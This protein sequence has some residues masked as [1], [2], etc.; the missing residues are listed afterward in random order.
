MATYQ[1]TVGNDFLTGTDVNDTFYGGQGDDFL[2]GKG[3]DDT[4]VLRGS[5]GWDDFDGGNGIDTISVQEVQG[6]WNFIAIQVAFLTS[7]EKIQN[8]SSTTAHIYAR[9]SL[10]LSN[11]EL[12]NIS[13]IRGQATGDYITGNSIANSIFGNDGAD[14]LKGLGGNDKLDGGTGNDTIAGGVGDDALYGGAG[15]DRFY[16][17]T[18]DAG[19]DTIH[20]FQDGI[21][22][23]QLKSGTAYTFGT[24]TATGYAT[25]DVGSAHVLLKG[26]A[27]SAISS[28]DLLFI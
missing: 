16:F 17:E 20:D 25:I 11:V 26:I 1:G 14:N 22:F 21:D 27:S 4:F 5:E 28:S 7:I 6:Y 13:E 24:D 23:I 15:A 3:G 12:I 19:N 8:L 18:T 2:T 9:Y 10:D